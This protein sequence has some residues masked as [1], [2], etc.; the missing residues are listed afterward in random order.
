MQAALASSVALLDKPVSTGRI[1][2]VKPGDD[3]CGGGKSAA[4]DQL[5]SVQ[6]TK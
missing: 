1:R 3:D 6:Y 2:P 4:P 5:L